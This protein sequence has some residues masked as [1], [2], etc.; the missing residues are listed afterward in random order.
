MRQQAGAPAGE[1]PGDAAKQAPR[2]RD[3]GPGDL[4][5]EAPRRDPRR[6]KEGA[7][8][9][10]DDVQRRRRARPAR[11]GGC[12]RSARRS[13]AP[14]C[15]GAG[16]SAI[17][18]PVRLGSPNR[19]TGSGITTSV[20]ESP[21]GPW[22][23]P[24]NSRCRVI[25]RRE[26]SIGGDEIERG[27]EPEREVARALHRRVA[28]RAASAAGLS[29]APP[30]RN[31]RAQAAYCRSIS[32]RHA[33]QGARGSI[34]GGRRRNMRANPS[35]PSYQS[36]LPGMPS[37]T[38]CL[39]SSGSASQHLVPGDD[40][41]VHG[42]RA[43][44]R[45]GTRCRRRRTGCRPRGAV[46]NCPGRSGSSAARR[47]RRPAARPRWLTDHVSRPVSATK[48]TRRRAP[49]PRSGSRRRD[50]RPELRAIARGE[51]VRLVGRHPVAASRCL[52]VAIRGETRWRRC[53][54]NERAPNQTTPRGLSRPRTK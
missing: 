8:A 19:C 1:L 31:S 10:G 26:L 51:L 33:D 52:S 24:R 41:P 12:R 11:S 21:G 18:V 23:A 47:P 39:P 27:G 6:V 22:A 34:P 43:R 42:S 2:L 16:S 9:A 46:R 4:G 28:R 15:R 40:D 3:A 48:S 37:S 35:R 36:W 20:A 7:A 54:Q 45:P 38:R 44:W 5:R 53:P 29:T 25:D 30:R 13:R 14:S 50:R 17:S 49:A 32:R